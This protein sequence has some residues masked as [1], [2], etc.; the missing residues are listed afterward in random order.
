MAMRETQRPLVIRSG[1]DLGWWLKRGA[2]DGI[3]V[4]IAF[5][6]FELLFA[7]A[8][9]GADAFGTPLRMIGAIIVHHISQVTKSCEL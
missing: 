2:V 7:A 6:V 8:M 9:L 4:G 5:I 3:L 1:A